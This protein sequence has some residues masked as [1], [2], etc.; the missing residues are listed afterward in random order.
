MSKYIKKPAEAVGKQSLSGLLFDPKEADGHASPNPRVSRTT[1]I[2][3]QNSV[4]FYLNLLK[5]ISP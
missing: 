5:S 1:D 4:L 2:T 3:T